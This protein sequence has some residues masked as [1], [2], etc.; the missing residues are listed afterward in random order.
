MSDLNTRPYACKA[1]ALTSWANHPHYARIIYFIIG[2]QGRTW[3]V[4]PLQATDFK[5]AVFT[6]F[7]TRAYG[8]P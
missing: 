7:T 3:T 4:K 8:E 6:N 1:Y 5:S 2:A